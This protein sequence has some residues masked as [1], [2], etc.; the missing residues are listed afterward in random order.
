MEQQQTPKTAQVSQVALK[1][2]SEHTDNQINDGSTGGSPNS[3]PIQTPSLPASAADNSWKIVGSPPRKGSAPWFAYGT[4]ENSIDEIEPMP[5][6]T[7]SFSSPTDAEV[8]TSRFQNP[9]IDPSNAF[10]RSSIASVGSDVNWSSFGQFQ[11]NKPSVW[12]DN[13]AP[14]AIQ[15][16]HARKA[17]LPFDSAF[18]RGFSEDIR[19]VPMVPDVSPA[20]IFRE[21]RSFSFSAGQ[22]RSGL[23]EG[24]D[25]QMMPPISRYGNSFQSSLPPM[26]EEEEDDAARFRSRS[27][28]SGAAFGLLS[29][30][31][32]AYIN[33]LN[34]PYHTRRASETY[35]NDRSN[36][37]NSDHRHPSLIGSPGFDMQPMQQMS[38]GDKE[39]LHMLQAQRRFSFAPD[40]SGTPKENMPSSRP[41]DTID[42]RRPSLINE[43]MGASMSTGLN[44]AMHRLNLEN[45]NVPDNGTMEDSQGHARQQMGEVGKGVPLHQLSGHR[46]LY[47]VEFK[48]GR[49]D[50]FYVDDPTG[51]VQIHTGD[52]VIVEADRGK[53]LGKVTIDNLTPQQVSMLQAQKQFE[54][55]MAADNEPVQPTSSL[56]QR[57]DIHPKRIYRLAVPNE[58]TSLVTKGEDEA[59]ARLLCQNKVRQK[60]L[61]MEVVDAEYQWDRRKL[62]FYF[63]ADRRIDFRELVRDLFK[64]YKTRIWIAFFP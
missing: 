43:Q 27:K 5:M 58:I 37:M 57:K 9:A 25:D 39:Q 41:I 45:A 30:S 16:A 12:S 60:K 4:K 19:S 8:N 34:N 33:Q 13:S 23:D 11:W 26:N 10:R 31:E 64:I 15:Q 55:Q 61:P 63:V 35:D 52:L 40:I 38:V 32:L 6:R 7:Q 47:M 51:T 44:D 1:P 29:S 14:D 53:D 56:Q 36:S 48:A 21:Q 18:G 22:S 2:T 20:G 54:Q 62:T 28:S 50:V 46:Q 49:T 17:S 24:G 3:E 42:E 59:K